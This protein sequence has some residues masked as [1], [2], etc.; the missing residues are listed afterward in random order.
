MLRNRLH[1]RDGTGIARWYSTD[2]VCLKTITCGSTESGILNAKT[3]T[4]T[5]AAATAAATTATTTT[6]IIIIT[7]AN[8]GKVSSEG[9]VY[10][11]LLDRWFLMKYSCNLSLND[12]SFVKNSTWTLQKWKHASHRCARLTF[13]DALLEHNYAISSGDCHKHEHNELYWLLG[14]DLR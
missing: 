7:A 12:F 13:I 3:T 14:L 1:R 2:G 9:P 11:N 4:T 5:A 6:A 8:K 10:D